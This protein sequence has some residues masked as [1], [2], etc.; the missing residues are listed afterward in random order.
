MENYRLDLKV[1]Q[2]R[3]QGG[4]SLSFQTEGNFDLFDLLWIS[5][6]QIVAKF[7]FPTNIKVQE[8]F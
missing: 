2:W 3:E 5:F 6:L 4:G 1:A 8:Y 7:P